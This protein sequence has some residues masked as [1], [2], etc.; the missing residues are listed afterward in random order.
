MVLV[1]KTTDSYHNISII[2]MLDQHFRVV[3]NRTL[4]ASENEV[5]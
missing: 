5:I 4:L 3:G 1:Y 2:L